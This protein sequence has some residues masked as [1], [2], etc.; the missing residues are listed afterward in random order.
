ME[1]EYNELIEHEISHEIRTA[2][3][4][5]LDI[6]GKPPAERWDNNSR[7]N[8]ALNADPSGKPVPRP[9]AGQPLQVPLDDIVQ[10]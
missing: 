5:R 3:I 8:K 2:E 9:R 7:Y 10:Q 6:F 1:Q 4:R